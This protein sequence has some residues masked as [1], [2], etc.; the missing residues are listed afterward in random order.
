LESAY[1]GLLAGVAGCLLATIGA[2]V[3]NQFLRDA[4]IHL[5]MTPSLMALGIG[6]SVLMGTCGGLYPAWRA[7][8]LLPMDAI[9]L[10]SH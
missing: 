10:G 8:Q 9:R 3:I 4:G 1:L 2:T 5:A 7:A 6:L